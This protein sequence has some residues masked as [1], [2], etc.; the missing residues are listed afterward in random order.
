MAF[1]AAIIVVSVLVTSFISGIFG[2]AGGLILMGVYVL[3][4]PVAQAMILHGMTQLASNG[5][6]CF[7][8]RKHIMF[9]ILRAYLLASLV[10][11]GLLTLISFTPDKKLVFL[12]MGLVPFV[13]YVLPARLV[14]NITSRSGPYVCGFLVTA[15]QL[16]A[17]VSGAI[18]DVFYVRSPLTR[19]QVIATKAFTQSLGHFIKLIYFGFLVASPAESFSLPWWI[20][21]LTI[22]IAITGTTLSKHV[23]HRINDHQFRRYSQWLLNV[24]G[25]FYLWKA[26]TLYL[27]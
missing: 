20:Y 12:V 13:G 19:H 2:M 16:T 10:C 26:A 25:I 14:P 11:A 21:A 15:M 22:A 24:I 9:S 17:G 27:Q 7:M 1:L 23:L 5:W 6:R 3:L 18:L 4:L 8:W